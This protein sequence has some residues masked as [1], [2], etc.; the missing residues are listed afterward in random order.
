MRKLFLALLLLPALAAAQQVPQLIYCATSPSNVACTT[1]GPALTGSGE[2]AWKFNGKTNANALLSFATL[3][4]ALTGPVTTV[5][6][7]NAT[8]INFGGGSLSGVLPIGN[9]GSGQA[10]ANNA[11]NAF[12]PSQAAQSGNCLGTNGTN[13]A[14]VTCGSGGGASAFSAITSGT[15]TTATMTVGSG[16]SLG[17]TGTGTVAATSLSTNLPVAN[18]NS[19]TSASS[20][21]FWRGD[22]T[23]A[24]PS[25]ASLTVGTTTIASGTSNDILY[26][27]AGTLGNLALGAGLSLASGSI[28]TVASINAQTGTSYTFVTGDSAKLVT[29]SNASATAVTLPVATTSGFGAGF[30]L[31]TQ[32]LGAGTVTITPTTSTIN[33]VATLVL[34]TNKGCSITSDGTNYQISACT[35]VGFAFVPPR[36]ETLSNATSFTPNVG[37]ADI[38]EQANTQAVGTL[39][40]NNPTGSAVDGQKW[41]LRIQSTNVQTFAWGT[42]YT[43]G[44]V[45]LPT[46]TSGATK[47][48]YFLF[49][50]NGATSKWNYIATAAGF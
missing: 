33:G 43:G 18:L 42:A 47:T 30:S 27:N 3:Q 19:G 14:W 9:G 45:A 23:W 44:T 20:S 11:L 5:G 34:T 26:D 29:F 25:A 35:A 49:M 36:T 38:S 6:N 7:S 21:T 41:T 28:A 24:T 13:S 12:L 32:N 15:N 10:T 22:A 31:D 48:D 46:V 16:G 8:A 40:A 1:S 37:V 39:T 4:P 2:P 50:F 17:T